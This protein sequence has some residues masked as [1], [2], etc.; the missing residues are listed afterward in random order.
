MYHAGTHLLPVQLP[1]PAPIQD[2]GDP[3]P[4]YDS[5]SLSL[6]AVNGA[7]PLEQLLFVFTIE[8]LDA[9]RFEHPPQTAGR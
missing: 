7:N 1:Q 6:Q 9:G 5:H 2:C 3:P 4:R 8:P